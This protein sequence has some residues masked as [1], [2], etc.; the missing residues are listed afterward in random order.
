MSIPE[1]RSVQNAIIAYCPDPLADT[2]T[3]DVYR[4][5]GPHPW[6]LQDVLRDTAVGQTGYSL[7]ELDGITTAQQPSTPLHIEDDIPLSEFGDLIDYIAIR[8]VYLALPTG[9]YSFLATPIAVNC[10][11]MFEKAGTLGIFKG[12]PRTTEPEYTLDGKQLANIVEGRDPYKSAVLAH[13]QYIALGHYAYRNGYDADDLS[14]HE[15]EFPDQTVII[16][17][18]NLDVFSK[19]K[20]SGFLLLVNA[21]K[22]KIEDFEKNAAIVEAEVGAC[23]VRAAGQFYRYM[24]SAV[25]ETPPEDEHRFTEFEP[26]LRKYKLCVGDFQTDVYDAFPEIVS[27][28]SAYPYGDRFASIVDEATLTHITLSRS[29]EQVVTA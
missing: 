14:L 12:D 15:F 4:V 2:P 27:P 22:I 23:R 17:Y 8:E 7:P 21:P 20:E 19:L 11:E 25:D 24:S 26:D 3:V 18:A 5:V 16:D 6:E 13:S 28:L 1:N 29:L 9:V 10:C